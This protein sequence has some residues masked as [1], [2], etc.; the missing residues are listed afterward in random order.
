MNST[1]IPWPKNIRKK[2]ASCYAPY[3]DGV[4]FSVMHIEM[5]IS[6]GLYC[7]N[8][9]GLADKAMSESRFRILSAIKNSSFDSPQRRNEKVTVNLAPVQNRKIGVFT[10]LAIIY[11]Y[12]KASGQL[13]SHQFYNDPFCIGEVT[14]DGKLT[15]SKDIIHLLHTGIKNGN[16]VFIIPKG[17]SVYLNLVED[18]YLMEIGHISDLR[19]PVFNWQGNVHGL[20]KEIL[21]PLIHDA[22]ETIYSKSNTKVN[23]LID[24]I[25]GMDPQKRI[26]LIALAGNHPLLFSGP[27][28]AGKSALASSA[29]ELL[30]DLSYR[31]AVEVH[32]IYHMYDNHISRDKK[33]FFKRPVRSPHHTV[34]PNK[35]IGNSLG[36]L[37]ELV[38]ANHGI[39]I[40][41]ELCEYS[42]QSIEALREPLDNFYIN[43]SKKNI[44]VQKKLSLLIIATT[45]LC[46][47]GNTGK[48][49][50]FLNKNYS[51]KNCTCSPYNIA[52]YRQKIS[53]PILDRFALVSYCS[54][55]D[56]KEESAESEFAKNED[57]T[58]VVSKSI[59]GSASKIKSE[60]QN[61]YRNR[62]DFS[63][64]NIKELVELARKRQIL[65]NPDGIYNHELHS[66]IIKT[67][68]INK[69]AESEMQ[70]FVDAF[71]LSGRR[72]EFCYRVARTI[73][74]IRDGQIIEREDILEALRYVKAAP[75]E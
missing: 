51:N 31:E 69:D 52:Q 8:I 54:Y 57:G 35:L 4:D 62:G 22:S 61:K 38:L 17:S 18:V 74:D 71:Q 44:S 32:G 55:Q 6:R 10:D 42:R 53:G 33:S 21:P 49:S 13:P 47:C 29:T 27:P 64:K 3:W 26:L 66:S 46:P 68:G 36:G 41:N 73:A 63:G 50:S 60:S 15:A 2:L 59:S 58:K 28:G 30:D 40:L 48:T 19:R 16:K 24:N 11:S 37:G 65:R 75:F 45:N 23:Y 70:N 25:V 67:F 5:D 1:S 12:L 20:D 14:L 9:V 34:T 39:L 56:R 72:I 7:F 43:V